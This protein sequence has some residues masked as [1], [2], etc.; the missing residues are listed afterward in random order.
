MRRYLAWHG[1]IEGGPSSP[2]NAVELDL[3]AILAFLKKH[4]RS[5]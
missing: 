4:S 1:T 2:K 3:E 5:N